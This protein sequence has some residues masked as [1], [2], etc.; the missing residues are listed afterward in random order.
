MVITHTEGATLT[1]DTSALPR[2]TQYDPTSKRIS[3]LG[4]VAGEYKITVKAEKGTQVA[5]K[6]INLT[7]TRGRLTAPDFSREVTVGDP[8]E[9]ILLPVPADTGILKDFGDL[10]EYGLDFDGAKNILSGRTRKVGNLS[11]TYT[12]TRGTEKA[13]GTINIKIKA[14]PISVNSNEQTV[15]VGSDNHSFQ[16]RSQRRGGD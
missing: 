3:G 12:L 13:T 10:G 1:V 15:T 5:Q 9:D 4:L 11:Y 8:I 14:K 2:G 7:I 6:E 16:N